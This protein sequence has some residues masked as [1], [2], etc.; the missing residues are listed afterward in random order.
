MSISSVAKKLITFL[1]E[2][3]LNADKMSIS[4]KL[5]SGIGKII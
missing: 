4:F 5:F 2:K 3:R 1:I